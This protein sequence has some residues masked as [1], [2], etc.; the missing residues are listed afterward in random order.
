VPDTEPPPG[1][2]PSPEADPARD[3]GSSRDAESVRDAEPDREDAPVRRDE[4][5]APETVP[6]GL[7]RHLHDVF[8]D[9]DATPAGRSF[10]D[11]A[12][13]AMRDLARRV[14]ADPQR[15]TV[16]GHGDADG[17]RLPGGRRLN[18]DELADLIRN[19]PNWNGREVLL[20]SCR[21]GDGDF[22][23]RLAQRLGVPVTAPSGLAWTDADGNVY[24]SSG[25]TS[26]DGQTRPGWPPDGTWRTSAPDGTASPAGR[27]GRPPG[28]EEHRGTDPARPGDDA[29]SRGLRDWF[30]REGHVDR[31]GYRRFDTDEQG[32]RYGE[33]RLAHVYHDLPHQL[34]QALHW[35]TV[36][37]MPNPHLRPGADVGR[38][39]THLYTEQNYVQHL[40]YLNGGAM[41]AHRDQLIQMWNRPDL[42]DYQRRLIQHVVTQTDPEAR[43]QEMWKNHEQREF[44][45]RYLGGEPT[46]DAFW[47]RIDELDQ[48]LSRPLPEPVQ[49]VRGLHDVNFMLASDGMPL[50]GRHP[51]LLVGAVQNEPG[52]MSTSLGSGTTEVDG[53]GF[54]Y[55]LS[56]NL[57]QGAHG[58]WMGQSSAYPDQ[59]ELVLPRGTRYYIR[60]VV[61]TGWNGTQPVFSIEADVIPPG[62]PP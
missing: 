40:A 11:P 32:E 35:Y 41:P 33:N 42:T 39:L 37:S 23:A 9:S 27:D 21:T 1:R 12:D 57:P 26:P 59:R 14:P 44:L 38:Y 47:R 62:T 52:Y 7:P 4:A 18:A 30:R 53:Q 15:F 60:N 43:L 45:R 8:R 31:D 51:M 20:L 29:Q 5:D 16:D 6:D 22:A 56:L 13:P 49:A 3:P 10:H 55:R 19:D 17:L 34:R 58:V 28:R 50:A 61:Q 54:N 24:A 2:G 48:A 36:Q 46:P 25:R